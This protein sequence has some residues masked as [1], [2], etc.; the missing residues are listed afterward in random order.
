MAWDRRGYFYISRRVGRR[1]V[2]EYYGKG[3]LAELAALLFERLR[4]RGP[5]P[6][7]HTNLGERLDRAYRA[8][9]LVDLVDPADPAADP[10]VGGPSPPEAEPGTP[11]PSA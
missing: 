11:A 3:P 7:G 5:A 6:G 4:R 9:G 10:L 8:L 1:V 2:R